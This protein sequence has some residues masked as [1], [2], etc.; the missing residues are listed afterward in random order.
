[1]GSGLWVLGL[2]VWM[3]VVVVVMGVD[4]EG[5][6]TVESRLSEVEVVVRN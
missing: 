6:G 2:G 3:V 1:M 4:N 5:M